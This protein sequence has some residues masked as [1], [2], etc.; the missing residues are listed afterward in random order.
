MRNCEELQACGP[1]GV[2]GHWVGA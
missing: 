1:E 2:S